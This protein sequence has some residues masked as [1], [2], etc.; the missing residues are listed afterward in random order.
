MFII[1]KDR[2]WSQTNASDL[3]G[4][5]QRTRNI[6]F[7]DEGIAKLAKRARSI[8]DF[9][10]TND[11]RILWIEYF[12][13]TNKYW[14]TVLDTNAVYSVDG[15]SLVVTDESGTSNIPSPDTTGGRNDCVPWQGYLYAT[16]T[17]SLRRYN[18]SGWSAPLTGTSFT[19]VTDAGFLCVHEQKNWLAISQANQVI[20]INTSHDK[21]ANTLTLPAEFRVTSMDYNNGFIAVGTRNINNGEAK[22]FLW[23]GNS[24]GYNSDF[25]VGCPRIDSIRRYKNTYVVLNSLGQLLQ[26]NGG[27]FTQI[28]AFPIYYKDADW[29]ADGSSYLGRVINRGMR[30]DGDL[31]YINVSPR[32]ILPAAD[33]GN[34]VFESYFEGGVWVYD[35]EV[36]LHH[37]YCHTSSL[38]VS[39]TIATSAVDTGTNTITVSSAPVSGTPVIYDSSSGTAI[40]GLT[41]RTKYYAIYVSA[42]T[43]KLSTTYANAI[44]GTPISLGGT[45]NNAQLL[46]FVPN[47]DFGGSTLGGNLTTNLF[48]DAA[49][50]LTF[51]ANRELAYRT[52]A[53]QVMFGTRI[54]KTVVNGSYGLAVA[55]WGQENRGF[56]MTPK[57][58]ANGIVDNFQNIS[59]KYRNVKTIEDK[60]IVKYRT[61]ERNDT[62]SGIDQ[63]L[64]MTATWVNTTQFTT[65][66]DLSSAKKGDEVSFH[67]GSGSGYMVHISSI[68]ES[69]GTY[70]VNLDEV[71]QNV[72]ASDTVGFVIENW[73]KIGTITNVSSS[74]T[75][76]ETFTNDN[77]DR[78]VGIGGIK[79]FPLLKNSKQIEI[80]LELRGEDVAIEDILV[81]NV[82]FK[83]FIA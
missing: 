30:V 76:N 17:T 7:D 29:D 55:T 69:G 68:S 50:A 20:L 6:S 18:G 5:V 46:I 57:L 33:L 16:S 56:I 41:N 34:H 61:I 38:R 39:N 3:S 51:V 37:R 78:Y 21:Q 32:I 60:I 82:P 19:G 8:H 67:S 36:G 74:D 77:L 59:V 79:T 45:G 31:I 71:V 24:T 13:A 70:T 26:F 58:K 54:G 52:N 40:T 43:M 23:D 27:G 42:T 64:T 11:R 73:N 10:G 47:R 49:G 1:P 15:T 4:N 81:N 53:S 22:M 80:K 35:P 62:L 25:G 65:T 14:V 9:S 63:A 2:K 83:R 72:T 66:A 44:A 48:T 28:G 12:Q 75:D